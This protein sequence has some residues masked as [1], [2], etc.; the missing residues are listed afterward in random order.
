MNV[1]LNLHEAHFLLRMQAIAHRHRLE[2][3]VV[4]ATDARSSE[5]APD[6]RASGLASARHIVHHY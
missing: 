2:S 1:H 4:H 5:L 6:E 3:V